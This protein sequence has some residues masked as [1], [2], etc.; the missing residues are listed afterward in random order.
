MAPGIANAPLRIDVVSLFPDFV[1]QVAGHGAVRRARSRALPALVRIV[2]KPVLA[3]NGTR[4]VRGCTFPRVSGARS[5]GKQ[6]GFEYESGRKTMLC[7]VDSCWP[8]R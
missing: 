2:R 4:N 8:A 6:L 3:W 5:R 1:A 7:D